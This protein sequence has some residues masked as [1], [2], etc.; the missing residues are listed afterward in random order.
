M[1]KWLIT[2]RLFINNNF[3]TNITS[4]NIIDVSPQLWYR[5]KLWE[6]DHGNEWDGCII[7][8][9]WEFNEE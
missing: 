1:K 4:T 9:I 6:K 2:Y 5:E 7:L 3:N 8:N